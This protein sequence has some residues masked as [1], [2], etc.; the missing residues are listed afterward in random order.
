VLGLSG[1]AARWLDRGAPAEPP[2]AGPPGPAV[3]APP[4][5]ERPQPQEL[6]QPDV[7]ASAELPSE[8]ETSLELEL[9][10]T[11]LGGP[12]E[13]GSALIADG[14]RPAAWFAVGDSVAGGAARIHE[15]GARRVVI[16]H[17]GR[18]ETVRL[19]SSAPASLAGEPPLDPPE[20]ASRSAAPKRLG[21][22]LG[23]ATADLGSLARF[24]A[25]PDG[26]GIEIDGL[27][28]GSPLAW[29]GLRPGDR[30][31]RVDGVPIE[32]LPGGLRALAEALYSEGG[33]STLTLQRF[34][35]SEVQIATGSAALLERAGR[36]P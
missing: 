16:E 21:I 5:A 30:I 4:A 6:A 22:D 8:T 31:L 19:A 24:T 23:T 25:N 17:R 33:T 1:F 18:L 10:G 13:R 28:R 9:L 36:R 2:S 12:G 3:A 15:V 20:A 7:A 34:D 11:L 32:S 29:L 35:G 14:D 27:E 26:P